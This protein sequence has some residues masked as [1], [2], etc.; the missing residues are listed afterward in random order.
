MSTPESGYIFGWAG[1]SLPAPAETL[2]VLRQVGWLPE[3]Q[4]WWCAWNELEILLPQR[5]GDPAALSTDWDELR[6]FSP[7]A[8]FRQVRRGTGW[9]CALLA[10][11]PAL[12][13]ALSGWQPLGTPYRV[14]SG[15]R[16]LWG[17]RLRLSGGETRGEVLFPRRLDYDVAGESPPY[18]QKALVADVRMYYDAEARLQAVRYAGLRH[19]PPGTVV[20]RP[21]PC[22]E[23]GRI[24]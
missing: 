5:L 7:Q 2:G 8:E 17:R 10:E 6:V 21:L 3:G 15:L 16:V 11:T 9:R 19:L 12:P 23:L 4:S 24:A 1:E 22:T 14:V 18:D 13:A 20:V